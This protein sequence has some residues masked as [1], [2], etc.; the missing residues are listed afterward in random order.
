MRRAY[1]SL[2]IQGPPSG[3][4]S[5]PPTGLVGQNAQ[6]PGVQGMPGAGGPQMPP[7]AVMRLP[8]PQTGQP[9]PNVS[10]PLSSDPTGAQ[11]QPGTQPQAQQISANTLQ[12][13]L[14]TVQFNLGGNGETP[15]PA[16]LVSSLIATFNSFRILEMKFNFKIFR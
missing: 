7:G 10:L 15:N 6:R 8:V 16:S 4:P 9:A 11:A 2:G 5:V 13:Q 12:Q 1:E 3:P 14:N